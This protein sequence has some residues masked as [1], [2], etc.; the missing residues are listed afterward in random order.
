[1]GVFLNQLKGGQKCTVVGFDG[2]ITLKLKR[3]LLELGFL[4]NVEITVEQISFLNE[5]MLLELNGFLV[6]L[7]SD[8]AKHIKIDLKKESVNGS[9]TFR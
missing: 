7:R 5:V 2:S 9:N 4:P 8:I 3:R 6:S 1:M